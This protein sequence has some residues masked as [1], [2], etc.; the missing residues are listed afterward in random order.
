MIPVI[1]GPTF[2]S[3]GRISSSA[4]AFTSTAWLP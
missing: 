3:F 2:R 1:V 4:I